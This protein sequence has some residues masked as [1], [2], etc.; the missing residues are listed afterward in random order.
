VIALE[1]WKMTDLMERKG[2][3]GDPDDEVRWYVL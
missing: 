2:G 3:A 1:R